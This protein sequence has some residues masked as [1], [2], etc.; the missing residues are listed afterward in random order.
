MRL[1]LEK[2]IHSY[3]SEDEKSIYLKKY[4]DVI[5]NN[6][7]LEIDDILKKIQLLRITDSKF[8]ETISK[9]TNIIDEL[10]K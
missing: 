7:N 6:N 8:Q 9:L 5:L 4:S 2:M 1:D 3:I 10:K